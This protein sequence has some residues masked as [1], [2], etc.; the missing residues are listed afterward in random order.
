MNRIFSCIAAGASV[1]AAFAPSAYAHQ[2]CKP[3]NGH[4]EAQVVPPGVGHCPNVPGVFCTAGHVWG[5]IQGRYQ[6][7]MSGASPAAAIGGIPTA[8]FFAGH[9]T[10]FMHDGS[11]VQGTDSGTLDIPPGQGGFA[12]LITF[13]SGATGQIRL[14]GFFDPAAGTTSGD[15]LGTF[16]ADS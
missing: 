5:G 12:S 4:F 7:V 16:C 2:A 8:L 13:D 15:Y 14:R 3:V 6:F 9:S 11:T 10:I 1:L